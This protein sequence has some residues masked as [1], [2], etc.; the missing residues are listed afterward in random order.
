VKGLNKEKN[1]IPV[2][3]EVL[4]DDGPG[5]GQIEPIRAVDVG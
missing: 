2:E 1:L 3:G 5:V 4:E